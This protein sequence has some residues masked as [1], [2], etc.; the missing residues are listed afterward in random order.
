LAS[1]LCAEPLRTFSRHT[2]PPGSYERS[3]G[4]LKTT[5]RY[6][7][8]KLTRELW[9]SPS[10]FD[11]ANY[12]QHPEAHRSVNNGC[13]P[14]QRFEHYSAAEAEPASKPERN[15]IV[16]TNG[17]LTLLS[18]SLLSTAP[19]D[20]GGRLGRAAIWG[21]SRCILA[22]AHALG[23]GRAFDVRIADPAAHSCRLGST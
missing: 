10:K 1:S 8:K 12:V 21:L 16:V 19:F 9:T 17:A 15:L 20:A 18:L 7:N 2:L 11:G 5:A 23:H 4:W 3:S 14:S 13:A 22:R 6:L